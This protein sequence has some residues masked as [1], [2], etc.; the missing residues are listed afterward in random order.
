[1]TVPSSKITE[2]NAD[3]IQASYQNLTTQRWKIVSQNEKI[4]ITPCSG[5]SN[6]LQ[7]A[8]NNSIFNGNGVDIHQISSVNDDRNKWELE[9]PSFAFSIILYNN[10]KDSLVESIQNKS[11][12][13]NKY[14]M[15]YT[16]EHSK[17]LLL[18]NMQNIPKI[19]V[20]CHARSYV[21][22][23]DDTDF[24]T[25]HDIKDL[26]NNAFSESEFIFLAG[27]YTASH[28]CYLNH[29]GECIDGIPLHPRFSRG[30]IDDKGI[31]LDFPYENICEAIYNKG[32]PIV[33][34]WTKAVELNSGSIWIKEFAESIANGLNVWEASSIAD[35]ISYYQ[36]NDPRD[37]EK[38]HAPSSRFYS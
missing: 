24:L 18:Y 5:E 12:A 30:E 10:S 23:N 8:V 35:N 37:P 16:A 32:A 3:I 27:C 17:S 25:I 38:T 14:G 19:L 33:G 29:T 36:Y 26:P 1:M 9:K 11:S 34:G 22:A 20:A 28:V 15:L 2:N 31:L 4:I 7:L 13:N 21:I 6:N